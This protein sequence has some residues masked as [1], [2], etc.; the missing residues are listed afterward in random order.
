MPRE[1]EARKRVWGARVGGW[2]ARAGGMSGP[3][4]FKVCSW[5]RGV[6][7]DFPCVRAREQARCSRSTPTDLTTCARRFR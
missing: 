5:L 6:T 1:V 3:R 4:V 2:A 7:P